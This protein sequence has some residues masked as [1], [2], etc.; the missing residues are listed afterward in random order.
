MCLNQAEG[1]VYYVNKSGNIVD[2][3]D[4]D[5]PAASVQAIKAAKEMQDAAQKN[6]DMGEQ[7]LS[8][9]KFAL[10][11]KTRYYKDKLLYIVEMKPFDETASYKAGTIQINLVDA[12]GFTLE[13][14][15]PKAW[16]TS[17][18]AK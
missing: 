9:T 12:T 8:G 17:V 13:T 3:V 2:V 4:L 7:S 18:D 15:E 16:F 5:I 1:K 14:I 10:T 11:L 6:R